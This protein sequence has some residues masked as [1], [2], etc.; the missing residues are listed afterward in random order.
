MNQSALTTTAL[1]ALRI[2]LGFLFAAHGWQ[3]FNEWT[4]AGT[5][6]SFA[7]MGIPAADLMAPAIAALELAGGIA[8]ILGILTRVVAALLVLDMLG[9]LVLVHA[10]AGVFAAKGGYELVLLL[11]AAAF[12]LALTG[13]GRLS[14]DRA[15]FGRSKSRLAALA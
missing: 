15:L 9:A 10:A 8:L 4:I 3:K 12:T 6:A 5:Q 7:K 1:A 13:A 14:L 2:V 11:A